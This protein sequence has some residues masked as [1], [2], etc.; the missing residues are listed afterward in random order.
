MCI[1]TKRKEYVVEDQQNLQLLGGDRVALLLRLRHR[2][3]GRMCCIANTHLSF[4]HCSIDRATQ[5]KQMAALIEAIEAFSKPKSQQ[6][7][8]SGEGSE[9]RES[10]ET[11]ETGNEAKASDA[12]SGGFSVVLGDFNGE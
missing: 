2:R 1:L 5:N 11:G 10:K 6:I 12:D 4:P 3:T 8:D 9:V 7:G